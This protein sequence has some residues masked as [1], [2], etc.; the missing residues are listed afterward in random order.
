MVGTKAGMERAVALRRLAERPR[1][2]AP[3][4]AGGHAPVLQA[5]IQGYAGLVVEL[6]VGSIV[7]A[8]V[9]VLI[10]GF[11]TATAPVA[12]PPLVS[13]PAPELHREMNEDLDP[14][15]PLVRC[16]M[17]ETHTHCVREAS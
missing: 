13:I 17:L 10:I 2:G 14:H 12:G 15:D 9:A 1:S 3:G 5:G 7:S 16:T 6:L 11:S 4:A 8:L